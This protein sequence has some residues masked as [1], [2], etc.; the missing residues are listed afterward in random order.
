MGFGVEDL[1]EQMQ[2]LRFW[3]PLS[4]TNEH[5]GNPADTEFGQIA[6]KAIGCLTP[7]VNW[8]QGGTWKLTR[9]SL[10]K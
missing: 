2:K 6:I 9:G 4:E 7:T 5:W 8:F 1:T 10:S 3:Q